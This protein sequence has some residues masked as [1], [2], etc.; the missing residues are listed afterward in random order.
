MTWLLMLLLLTS[1]FTL[2]L[3]TKYRDMLY[4][5]KEARLDDEK[6]FRKKEQAWQEELYRTLVEKNE[7]IDN[8]EK[9]INTIRGVY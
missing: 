6:E 7:H 9:Q 2:A 8:L 4:D 3:T 5:E 1:L